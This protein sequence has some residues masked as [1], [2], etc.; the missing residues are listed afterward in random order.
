MRKWEN[1]QLNLKTSTWLE[2][3]VQGRPSKTKMGRLN[4]ALL[5]YLTKDEFRVLTAVSIINV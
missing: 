3:L 4:A 1:L 2:E 5:R